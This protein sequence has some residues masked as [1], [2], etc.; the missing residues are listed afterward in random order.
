MADHCT[1][2]GASRPASSS[3][4]SFVCEYCGAKNVDE[5]YFIERAKNIDSNKLDSYLHLGLVAFNAGDFPNAEQKFEEAVKQDGN[6]ADAWIYLA[7]TKAK[8][9]KPSNFTNSLSIATN[10]IQRAR[11]IDANAEIVLYGSSAIANSFLARTISAAQYYFETADKRFVAYGK[12]DPALVKEVETGFSLIQQAFAM[13]PTESELIAASSCYALTQCYKFEDRGFSSISRANEKIYLEKL[14]QVY[15]KN[16]DAAKKAIVNSTKYE[17]RINNAIE[18]L[19]AVSN[20][21][22]ST[23][24]NKS[25]EKSNSS[26]PIKNIAIIGGVVAIVGIGGVFFLNQKPSA[27]NQQI[28]S[29]VAPQISNQSESRSDQIAVNTTNCK[30]IDQCIQFSLKASEDGDFDQVRLIAIQIDDFP[31]PELGNKPLSRKLNADGLNYFRQD[32]FASA[33][34]LFTQAMAENPRDVEVVGNLGYSYLKFGKYNDAIKYLIK[35]LSIDPKRSATWAPLAEAYVMMGKEREGLA[36]LKISYM[37]AG[38][39]EKSQKAYRDQ[40][41]KN[42]SINPRLSKLYSEML[43]FVGN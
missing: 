28:T 18:K 14:F 30:L 35:A 15:S 3:N 17:H 37:W 39:K 34:D 38:N 4:H 20:T 11:E 12:G 8:T 16:Q 6:S 36:A 5:Q 22:K 31:K 33:I 27:T 29:S 10:C 32:N 1:S 2:C 26:L 21:S 7:H 40:L 25:T 24:G 13:A 41:E 43:I 19:S 42:E 23:S 9:V